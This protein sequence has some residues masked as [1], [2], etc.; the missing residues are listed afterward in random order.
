ML[1]QLDAGDQ[2]TEK[3]VAEMAG[4][5]YLASIDTVKS[6]PPNRSLIDRFLD[7]RR[8]VLFRPGAAR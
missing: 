8:D 4:T 5:A 6:L 7:K 3:M 1:A 2:E